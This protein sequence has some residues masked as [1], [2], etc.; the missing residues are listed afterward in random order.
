MVHMNI[1]APKQIVCLYI[2]EVICSKYY[3]IQSLP[4]C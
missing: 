4:F 3:K 2:I 1:W